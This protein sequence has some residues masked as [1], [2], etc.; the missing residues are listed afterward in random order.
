MKAPDWY[1]NVGGSALSRPPPPPIPGIGGPDGPRVKAAPPLP[2]RT[3]P[4]S[5]NAL[6]TSLSLP[7]LP[8]VTN[9]LA[10]S[11][12]LPALPS[13]PVAPGQLGAQ[14]A[15]P[16]PPGAP[17][18]LANLPVPLPPPGFPR[19]AQTGGG[20]GGGIIALALQDATQ[21]ALADK[22][23]GLRSMVKARP[24]VEDEKPFEIWGLQHRA[25]SE[26]EL[27]EAFDMLDLDRHGFVGPQ[28]IRRALDLCGVKNVEDVEVKEM[29]RLVDTDARGKID[30]DE[31]KDQFMEPPMVFKNYDMH[32]RVQD[33]P[34]LPTHA[35]F[36]Q[37]P[38]TDTM[39]DEDAFI[40]DFRADRVRDIM[41]KRRLTPEFIKQVYQRFI[42][43]DTDE[44]GFVNFEDFC[45]I[46]RRAE[47]ETMR[48]A[49]DAFDVDRLGELD[50]RNFIVGLS[51]YTTSNNEE[52]LRFA[53]MMFDENQTEEICRED[54]AEL[55]KAIAPHLREELRVA[56]VTRLYFLLELDPRDDVFLDQFLDYALEFEDELVP[57]SITNSSGSR[58]ASGS[59]SSP[60]KSK[61]TA[62]SERRRTGGST[63]SSGHSSN[64]S[65]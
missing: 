15:L 28:D 8:G 33:L 29:L 35:S 54:V 11:S 18:A 31:F 16:P 12:S 22:Q 3:A 30:F 61:S 40:T 25:Y 14:Q 5:Q 19:D 51:M 53:F 65:H 60:G 41:G 32:G 2:G 49:F 43:L 38:S 42:E 39:D 37:R 6:G 9:T 26:D 27:K 21:T 36:Q 50:L 46:L 45:F 13:I 20:A 52:K 17:P 23:I 64:E 44:R 63:K 59:G 57:Q 7:A 48:R 58:T 4:L 1:S 56:H 47:N 10:S 34:V 62:P 55:L 24:L